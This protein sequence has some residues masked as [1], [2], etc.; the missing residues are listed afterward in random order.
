MSGALATHWCNAAYVVVLLASMQRDCVFTGCVFTWCFRILS[1]HVLEA[2]NREL[3]AN[4]SEELAM[5]NI[6]ML[7][8]HAV[9]TLAAGTC[10]EQS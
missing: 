8:E 6:Q 10:S 2:M 9:G 1:F 4:A 5:S 3:I 7:S